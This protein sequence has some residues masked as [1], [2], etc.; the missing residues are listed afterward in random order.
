MKFFSIVVSLLV[1][2]SFSG[3]VLADCNPSHGKETPHKMG[4]ISNTQFADLDAD[5]SSGISFEE[6]KAV[7]P[8]ISQTGFKML[9]KDNDTQLDEMEWKAFQDVHK[10]RYNQAPENT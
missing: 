10:G 2:I 6:F 4:R 3:P 7:F 9:D 1:L 8:T 5:K